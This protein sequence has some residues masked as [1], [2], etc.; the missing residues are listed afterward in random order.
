MEKLL[1]GYT[2][3]DTAY[4]VGD[5]PYGFKLRTNIYYWVEFRV[6]KGYRFRAV[7]RNP[8][9]GKMN[10]PKYS[11]YACVLGFMYLNIKDHVMWECVHE[12]TP[13]KDIV[14]FL[15]RF[16]DLPRER[17]RAWCM[18]KVALHNTFTSTHRDIDG[19]SDLELWE[20]AL[21]ACE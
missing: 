8:K 20:A 16:P 12:Y 5:Y 10:K 14:S 11:T 6:G 17:L 21:A 7:T 13:A 19:K 15:T 3:Q 18:G 1:Q 9:N 2:S 4:H